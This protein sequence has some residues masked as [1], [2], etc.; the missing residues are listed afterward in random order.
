MALAPS[1]L[2]DAGPWNWIY[3]QNG[4]HVDCRRLNTQRNYKWVEELLTASLPPSWNWMNNRRDKSIVGNRRFVKIRLAE[5]AAENL[6]WF[7]QSLALTCS[8]SKNLEYCSDSCKPFPPFV[9]S[10]IFR[11]SFKVQRSLLWPWSSS[12]PLFSSMFLA[13][14]YSSLL[15]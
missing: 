7:S 5:N 6:A 1:Y 12:V 4:S 10:L 2:Q 13:S 9:S 3:I 15:V 11:F 14:S 8:A